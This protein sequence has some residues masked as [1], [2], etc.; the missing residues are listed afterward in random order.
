MN[1]KGAANT[2]SILL[3]VLVVVLVTAVAYLLF[4]GKRG[5]GSHPANTWQGDGTSPP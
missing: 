1:K 5:L 2:Q 3:S 4:T